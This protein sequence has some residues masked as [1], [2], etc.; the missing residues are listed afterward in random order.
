M[1]SEARTE[2]VLA[3]TTTLHWHCRRHVANHLNDAAAAA[4]TAASDPDVIQV[5]IRPLIASDETALAAGLRELSAESK[6]TRFFGA[7]IEALTLDQLH[8]LCT[9]G[10][11]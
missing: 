1:Q 5:M 8:Y 11:E 7:N 6:F 9:T 3:H 4:A 10:D 2:F